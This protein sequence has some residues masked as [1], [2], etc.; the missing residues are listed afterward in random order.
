MRGEPHLHSCRNRDQHDTVEASEMRSGFDQAV[1]LGILL[2][3]GI[4]FTI[5]AANNWAWSPLFMVPVAATLAWPH[6][7][8]DIEDTV[9]GIIESLRDSRDALKPAHAT[10]EEPRWPTK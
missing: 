6:L 8:S 5:G 7:A 2:T 4:A 10:I 9:E 1:Q 3:S